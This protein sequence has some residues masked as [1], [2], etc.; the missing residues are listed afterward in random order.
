MLAKSKEEKRK[1]K[2]KQKQAQARRVKAGQAAADKG[3]LYYEDAIYYHDI[4]NLSKALAFIQ[5]AVKLLPKEEEVILF[6]GQIGASCNDQKVQLDALDCLEKIGKLSDL[7]RYNRIIFLVNLEKYDSCL[8]T[9]EDLLQNFTQLHLDDKRRKKANVKDIIRYCKEQ[10]AAAQRREQAMRQMAEI[11]MQRDNPAETGLPEPGEKFAPGPPAPGSSVAQPYKD[12]AVEKSASV[13]VTVNI[14]KDAFVRALAETETAGPDLYELALM[15]HKIRF[16]ESFETLICLPGLT[17]ITSFWYQEE[18]AKKVLKQ[19][20]GRALLSDE[21]GLGKTIEALIILSEYLRRGMVKTAL[22]LTPTPLVSQW[23]TEMASKFNL[24]VQSTDSPEFK[25]G[26]SGFWEQNIVVASINQAKSKKNWNLITSREYDM[27][28]VDEAHHLKN[29][30]TL[31]FKLVNALKKKFILLL[32]ATPVENNLMELYNLITLLKPGQLETATSFRERFM[33]RGDPTDPQN[34]EMLKHLLSQVMIR[35]TRALA[36][37]HIPPRFASTIRIAP[38][39][40]ESAFY[41]RLQNLLHLLNDQKTGRAKLMIKNLLAQAG[42]SP[43]AVEGS[44]DRMLE[45]RSWLLEIENEIKAVRNLCRTTAD[46]PKNMALLKLVKADSEKLLV[47]VKYT[48][49]LEYLAEFLEWN[50]ISFVLFHGGMANELKDAAIQSFKEDVQVLVTTEIGG[51][52]RNIQFCSRMV[53]YDLPWNPMKIEQRIGRIH[54]IGQEKQVQIYNFCAQGSIED[55]ILDILDRKINMF[56]MVIGEIDMI[57][58]RVTGE[59]EF[60]DMVC[61]IWV[62][63]QSLEERDQSFAKLGTKLKRAK[64]GYEK[65]RELDGKLFGDSYEL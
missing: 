60:S 2:R 34:R 62:D 30:S 38:T 36:G 37:I 7:M 20:R 28:I 9:A 3:W 39:A 44:L 21:V 63:S 52:G 49:T 33:K 58:G 1:Q 27:V 35:N 25:S 53:N 22:I 45:N 18:T 10:I 46:T 54:R 6:M 59:K 13:P 8:K 65:T 55:Y 29:K 64:T 31:N 42:S 50:D 43:K 15:S 48:A 32:T 5:K 14:D 11:Y 47:F 26:D 40:G 12:K 61:D 56:E 23:Q 19:F 51:E 57:L 24:R 17:E 16:A 41:E 4:N